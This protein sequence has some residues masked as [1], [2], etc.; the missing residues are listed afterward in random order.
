MIDRPQDYLKTQRFW[1]VRGDFPLFN[2]LLR[3]GD[4]AFISSQ[5]LKFPSSPTD[6]RRW[7]LLFAGLES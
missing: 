1:T 3:D 4:S 6:C 7:A 2:S 5:A